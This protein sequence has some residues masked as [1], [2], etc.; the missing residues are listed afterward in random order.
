[1]NGPLEENSSKTADAHTKCLH[2]RIKINYQKTPLPPQKGKRLPTR[3]RRGL[4]VREIHVYPTD[5]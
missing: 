5:K 4:K 3:R 2:R 1:M